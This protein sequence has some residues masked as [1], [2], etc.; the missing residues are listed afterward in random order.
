MGIFQEAPIYRLTFNDGAT[1]TPGLIT[2]SYDSQMPN[3]LNTMLI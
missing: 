1:K 3:S 2:N